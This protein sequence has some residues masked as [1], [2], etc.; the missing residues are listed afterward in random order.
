MN[1]NQVLGSVF[2]VAELYGLKIEEDQNGRKKIRSTAYA[3][4]DRLPEEVKV[5]DGKRLRIHLP[6]LREWID[7]GGDRVA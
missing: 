3:L 4:M 7:S 2:E 6:K 5:R 1:D